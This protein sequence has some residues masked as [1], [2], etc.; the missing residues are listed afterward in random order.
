M[1]NLVQ[2]KKLSLYKLFLSITKKIYE[3]HKAE[4]P[5][6]VNCIDLYVAINAQYHDY[7]ELFKKW[8]IEAYNDKLIASAI[9]FWFDD[10]DYPDHNK[11]QDYFN[12]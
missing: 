2:N 8:F 5:T 7:N 3:E 6:Y 12:E 9:D 11:L 10:D 4:L 1:V